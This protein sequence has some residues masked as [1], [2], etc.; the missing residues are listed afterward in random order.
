MLAP[1][2]LFFAVFILYPV[3]LNFYYSFTDYD[4]SADYDWVGLKN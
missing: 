2:L 4:L 1:F 3:T